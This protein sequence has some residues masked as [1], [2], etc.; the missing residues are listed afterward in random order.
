MAV[1]SLRPGRLVPLSAVLVAV[2][3]VVWAVA[4]VPR[5]IRRYDDVSDAAGYP[6]VP[7]QTRVLTRRR[8]P[9]PT[10][11]FGP[12]ATPTLPTP[13]R[14][15]TRSPAP[16]PSLVMPASGVRPNQE[17]RLRRRRL[18]ILTGLVAVVLAAAAGTAVG[19]L[20]WPVPLAASGLL[21]VYVLGLRRLALQA[22]YDRRRSVGRR[23]PEWAADA[24]ADDFE[25]YGEYEE[26]ATVGAEPTRDRWAVISERPGVDV[27]AIADAAH[28]DLD[29]ESER[30]A[31]PAEEPAV[32]QRPA[33]AM[34]RPWR[35]VPVPL[36]TYVT[37]GPAPR[38]VDEWAEEDDE[39]LPGDPAAYGLGGRQRRRAVGG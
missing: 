34:G 8:P 7:S 14:T 2:V 11:R 18:L 25:E 26:Y 28:R 20:P 23:A 22:A 19:V 31:P 3:V 9:L 12:A 38:V 15:S 33:A 27:I 1:L 10:V 16:T 4:I 39:A 35:P 6:P 29:A 21:A 17:A 37:A 24:F 30:A 32:R 13:A 5:W 36:P